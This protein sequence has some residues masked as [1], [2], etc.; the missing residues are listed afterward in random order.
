MN[1]SEKYWPNTLFIGSSIVLSA[2]AQLLMK[3]GMQELGSVDLAHA[4]ANA[5]AATAHLLPVVTWILA[6]LVFY[7]ISMLFWLAALAKYELSMAYPLLSLSYVLVYIGA[8]SWP[9]LHETV[10]A[11]KTIGIILII[12]G[13]YLVTRTESNSRNNSRESCG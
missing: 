8:A 10:S 11:L 1:I 7:A 2:G 13:V 5:S 9:R 4:L 3:V 6:G 12:A